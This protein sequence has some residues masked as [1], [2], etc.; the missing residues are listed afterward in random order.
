M[1]G[2]RIKA[3]IGAAKRRGR[4]YGL[5]FKRKLWQRHVSALGRAALIQEANDRAKA[6]RVYSEWALKQPGRNAGTKGALGF[7]SR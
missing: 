3:A 6:H 2:E 7:A 1:I 4:K 5:L